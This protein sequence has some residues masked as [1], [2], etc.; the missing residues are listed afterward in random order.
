LPTWIS[1]SRDLPVTYVT[2][3]APLQVV[4]GLLDHV[5][6]MLSV[7]CDASTGYSVCEASDGAFFD[8]R[9][10]H[11]CYKGEPIGVMGIIHP[12]ALAN[13]DIPFPASAIEIRLD[14]FV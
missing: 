11:V 5:M 7:P 10:A 9:C 8:G 6:D 2:S 12:A 13:F 1:P 14:V 3:H 4:H